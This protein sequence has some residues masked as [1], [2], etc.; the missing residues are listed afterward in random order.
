MEHSM[1]VCRIFFE[2]QKGT[3]MSNGLGAIPYLAKDREV[4]NHRRVMVTIVSDTAKSEGAFTDARKHVWVYKHRYGRL[5]VEQYTP[6]VNT[7]SVSFAS[8]Y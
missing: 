1:P 3:N 7:V 8:T 6:G 4:T 2:Q 5:R